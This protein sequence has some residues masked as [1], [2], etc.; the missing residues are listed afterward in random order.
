MH[1][2]YLT[3]LA[4]SSMAMGQDWLEDAMDALESTTYVAH[5]PSKTGRC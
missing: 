3:F 4:L 5:L 2:K 1:A